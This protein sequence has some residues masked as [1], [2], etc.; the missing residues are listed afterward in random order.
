MRLDVSSVF[1]ELFGPKVLFFTLPISIFLVV[2]GL[3]YKAYQQERLPSPYF[4]GMPVKI[5]G[6][7]GLYQLPRGRLLVNVIKDDGD[8]IYI[9]CLPIQFLCD[10]FSAGEKIG[11]VELTAFH[12]GRAAYWPDSLSIGGNLVLSPETSFVAYEKYRN[13]EIAFYL[14]FIKIAVFLGIYSLVIYIKKRK[15]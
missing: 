2:I 14:V 6:V 1:W 13:K 15:Q 8:A 10:R 9:D 7:A 11:R 5:T 4:N 12:I 3:A